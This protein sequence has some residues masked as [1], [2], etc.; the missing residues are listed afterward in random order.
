MKNAK[1]RMKNAKRNPSLEAK[2]Q[3]DALDRVDPQRIPILK[4]D[5]L[6]ILHFLKSSAVSAPLRGNRPDLS[7]A[8]WPLTL[9]HCKMENGFNLW[10]CTAEG[11]PL[12]RRKNAREFP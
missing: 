1:P 9:D 4:N 10:R 8:I 3:S 12:Q 5:A 7:I 11:K 2:R 6:F